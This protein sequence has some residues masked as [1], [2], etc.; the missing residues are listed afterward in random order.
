M[1]AAVYFDRVIAI[2]RRAGFRRITLRGDTDFSQTEHLDR[3]NDAGVEFVFGFDATD[4]LY[5]LA[6]KLPDSAWKPLAASAAED[7]R[8]ASLAATER[9]GADRRRAG[10]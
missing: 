6:E 5:A 10:I 4:K 8:Q 1:N 7:L 3:W 9:Q 2:C